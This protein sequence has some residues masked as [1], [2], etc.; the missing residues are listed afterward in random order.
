MSPVLGAL[1]GTESEEVD[2]L[3]PQGDSQHLD[4]IQRGIRPAS[5]HPRNVRAR[6]A[7][8]IRK[9]FLALAQCISQFSHAL[10]EPS[11]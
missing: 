5:L 4:R 9:R 11:S 2:H 6:E 8:A 10:A 1:A 7:A 3:H